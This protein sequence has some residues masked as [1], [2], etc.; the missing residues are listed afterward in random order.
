MPLSIVPVAGDEARDLYGAALVLIRPDQI[1]AWRG[2]MPA[3]ALAVLRRAAG[4]P[5]P[6]S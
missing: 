2:N 3:A 6:A 5:E 4:H 1:V